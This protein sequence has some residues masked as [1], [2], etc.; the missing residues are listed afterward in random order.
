MSDKQIRIL[1]AD[2]DDD[3]HSLVQAVLEPEG[4]ELFDAYNGDEALEKALIEKPDLVI[5]DVMMPGL[6]GW[7]LARYFRSKPEFQVMGILMLTGIG[8]TVNDMTSPLFGADHHLDKPFQ[9]ADLVSAV[10]NVL[11]ERV[12][13]A[14]QAAP[15]AD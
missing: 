8:A 7:E 4:Y 11:S 10:S 5:L 15:A 1:I 9:P 3:I 2:D 14:E 12:K 6:N 13:R